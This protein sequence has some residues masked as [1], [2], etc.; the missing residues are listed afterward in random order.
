MRII[1][2]TICLNQ[3]K[4]K[5]WQWDSLKMH[6]G[7]NFEIQRIR[8]RFINT[9]RVFTFSFSRRSSQVTEDLTNRWNY[10]TTSYLCLLRNLESTNKKEASNSNKTNAWRCWLI[11]WDAFGSYLKDWCSSRVHVSDNWKFKRWD[12]ILKLFRITSALC[13]LHFITLNRI[14]CVL[15]ELLCEKHQCINGL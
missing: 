13:W 15:M 5:L 12:V 14:A 4:H 3:C 10:F 9:W 2:F 8:E 7:G 1:S 11:G 6:V